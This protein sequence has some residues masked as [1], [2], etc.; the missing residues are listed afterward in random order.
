MTE[1]EMIESQERQTALLQLTGF[2]L[3]SERQFLSVGA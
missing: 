3:S 1:A 2:N